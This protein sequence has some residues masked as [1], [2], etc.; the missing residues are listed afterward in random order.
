MSDT[1]E[2]CAKLERL[3]RAVQTDP[4]NW[5]HSDFQGAIAK[6]VGPE[7]PYRS[8]DDSGLNP[9]GDEHG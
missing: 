3:L 1:C 8:I 5:L 2:R 9:K 6:E 7:G 4:G